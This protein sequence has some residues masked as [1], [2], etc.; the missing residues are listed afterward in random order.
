MATIRP[1]MP[2]RPLANSVEVN[3][4]AASA[5]PPPPRSPRNGRG[6]RENTPRRMLPANTPM[7]RARNQVSPPPSGSP[8]RW[9]LTGAGRSSPSISLTSTPVASVMPPA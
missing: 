2:A 4:N 8:P 9:P 1:T 5:A 6:T 7:N 3:R